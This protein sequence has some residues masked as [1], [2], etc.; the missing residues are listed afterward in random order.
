MGIFK[1][2]CSKSPGLGNSMGGLAGKPPGRLSGY[3]CKN[4]MVDCYEVSFYGRQECGC[5]R[6]ESRT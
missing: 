3:A 5:V 6:P 1:G 2:A 4:H